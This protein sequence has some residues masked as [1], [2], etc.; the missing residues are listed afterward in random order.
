MILDAMMQSPPGPI[1]PRF[2]ETQ[3]L[4]KKAGPAWKS[5]ATCGVNRSLQIYPDE[6]AC[7]EAYPSFI[8]LQALTYGWQW[9][10]YMFQYVS[11]LT[12]LTCLTCPLSRCLTYV[13]Y[14]K[15]VDSGD[16]SVHQFFHLCRSTRLQGSFQQ[17]CSFI[18]QA[19]GVCLS[20]CP[21]HRAFQDVPNK[22]QVT[23]YSSDLNK[24]PKTPQIYQQPPNSSPNPSGTATHC[25]PR[26]RIRHLWR[27][28]VVPDTRLWKVRDLGTARGSS[29]PHIWYINGKN[30]GYP[31]R[32]WSRAEAQ[33]LL[34]QVVGHLA[35]RH[36]RHSHNWMMKNLKNV[37]HVKTMWKQ[38]VPIRLLV[39]YGWPLLLLRQLWLGWW[40]TQRPWVSPISGICHCA[41]CKMMQHEQRN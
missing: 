2:K 37:K 16:W 23:K 29:W 25:E 22:N 19:V 30:Q 31:G 28:P 18:H 9:T 13:K 35:K 32:F 24:C 39:N 34:H 10:I 1:G 11:Y 41:N 38:L 17:R 8:T 33:E 6:A 3:D 15:S 26:R 7:C 5:A 12:D 20:H 4:R 40:D 27:V 21:K 14:V 36:W